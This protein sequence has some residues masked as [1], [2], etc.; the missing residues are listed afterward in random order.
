[1]FFYGKDHSFDTTHYD[2]P[3][4]QDKEAYIQLI[5]DH[6]LN[7]NHVLLIQQ[8]DKA[9]DSGVFHNDVIS[10]GTSNVFLYHEFTASQSDMYNISI[11]YKEL[12][13][14]PLHMIYL[15]DDLLPLDIAVSSYLFNSQIISLN[16]DDMILVAPEECLS[17]PESRQAIRYIIESSNPIKRVHFINLNQSMM[18]GGGPA[19]LRLRCQLNSHEK[20]QI[21][22][23][24]FFT[25]SLY[26]DLSQYVN[27]YY[28]KILTLSDL[29]NTH[30]FKRF[31]LFIMVF[32]I[33][34]IYL[35]RIY[36]IPL[37][38]Q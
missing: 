14:E 4:R 22:H 28:P 15:P 6:Q 19:C 31:R 27:K 30:F 8:H 10:T 3:R 13:H 29:R 11:L 38:K 1:M 25:D 12:Y 23:S 26:Q 9:I 17:Y 7:P 36:L 21:P 2:F 20:Q 5:D 37:S 34:L 33:T 24:F 35:C 16:Q 18:N 32:M